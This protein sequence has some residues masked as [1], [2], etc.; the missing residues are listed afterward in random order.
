MAADPKNWAI[1]IGIDDYQNAAWKLN[2]AVNDALA[3]ADWVRTEGCVPESNLR[4]LL[5]PRAAVPATYKYVRAQRREIYQV[6]L[7][8]QTG[9]IAADGERLYFYYSGHGAAIQMAREGDP[10]DLALIPENVQEL[11]MDSNE[12]LPFRDIFPALMN[13]GPPVQFFFLDA[14]RDFEL[15]QNHAPLVGRAFGRYIGKPAPLGTVP[16][17]QY[18]IYSTSPGQKA[19]ELGTGVFGSLLLD[20]LR[21]IESGAMKW[22]EETRTFELRFQRMAAF[23]RDTLQLRIQEKLPGDWQK[24]VQVPE[25]QAPDDESDCVVRSFPAQNVKKLGLRVRVSPREALTD[26]RVSISYY[27]PGDLPIDYGH[28][29]P[30]SKFPTDFKLPPSNYTVEA[31]SDKFGSAMRSCNLYREMAVEL[32][33]QSGAEI[34]PSSPIVKLEKLKLEKLKLEE[35]SGIVKLEELPGDAPRKELL[36]GG[37]GSITSVLKTRRRNPTRNITRGVDGVRRLPPPKVKIRKDAEDVWVRGLAPNTG[38]LR[39]SCEDRRA[40]IQLTLPTGDTVSA[41]GVLHQ[42]QAG[43]GIYRA[44]VL[45]G[46]LQSNERIIDL[47]PGER[48]SVDLDAPATQ[49]GAS[50]MRALSLHRIT[51]DHRGYMHPSELVGD[52]AGVRLGNILA[53][54][55][56]AA[57]WPNNTEMTRLRSLG[58]R[59]AKRIRPSEGCVCVLLGTIERPG[60]TDV[61][62]SA[63]VVDGKV[64]RLAPLQ[65]PGTGQWQTSLPAGG[66]IVEL[67]IAGAAR[68]R[69]PVSILP[70]RITVVVTTVGDRGTSERR[71]FCFPINPAT[72]FDPQ[73]LNPQKLLRLDEAQERYARAARMDDEDMEQLLFGKWLDPLLGCMGGYALARVGKLERYI[74][75]PEPN[76]RPGVPGPS[77]MQNMLNLFGDLPDSHILAGLS[78]PGRADMHFANAASRGV[79]IFAEG[80]EVLREW[81]ASRGEPSPVIAEATRGLIPGAAFTSWNLRN[82]ALVLENNAMPALP[83]DWATLNRSK[84]QIEQAIA[85]TGRIEVEGPGVPGPWNGAA[86]LVAP[87]IAITMSHVAEAFAMRKG[88]GWQMR[89]GISAEVNFSTKL[90]D[91]S[92]PQARVVRVL[93]CDM[94]SKLAVIE[95]QFARGSRAPQPLDMQSRGRGKWEGRRVYMVGFPALDLA[96]VGPAREDS[97]VGMKHLQPGFITADPGEHPGNAADFEHDCFTLAGDAGAPV[98]DAE[99]HR[100]LGMHHSARWDGEKRGYALALWKVEALAAWTKLPKQE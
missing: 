24:C 97:Q 32:A 92:A 42:A 59:P 73:V 37:S 62:E 66:H 98:I 31:R 29:G 56:L 76:V 15:A 72:Q 80:F 20:A 95:I 99:T 18:T 52:L 68:E 34:E 74:G 60:A 21:G 100:V 78:E 64:G 67:R 28:E 83:S 40:R 91:R 71:L 36:F 4:L 1:V 7:D 8:I 84:K 65:V 54:S 89:P 49:L 77:A 39:L 45:A 86:F 26:C 55:V 38:D 25:P 46:S 93:H 16:R 27:G 53:L 79:P 2:G 9:K 13:A 12:A 10:P 22:S 90:H 57:N 82:P 44:R 94:E 33:L 43:P 75:T 81:Q 6:L 11:P 69:L 63:A 30:P 48:K 14:C 41:R 85:A 50:Q 35:L 5:S 96:N 47:R 58:V 87:R 3:F 19:S 23:L 51:A 70:G 88:S 61:R 17:K